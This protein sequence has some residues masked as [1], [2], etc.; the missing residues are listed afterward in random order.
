[1][2]IIL[3][4]LATSNHEM[5]LVSF[6]CASSAILHRIRPNSRASWIAG[7]LGQLT[8]RL[9]YGLDEPFIVGSCSRK[10]I[11]IRKH[12]PNQGFSLG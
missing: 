8:K 6:A 9:L 10:G 1:M 3:A 11:D 4:Q 12:L 7:V 2:Q 5:V